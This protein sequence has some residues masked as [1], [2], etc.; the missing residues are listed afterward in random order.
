MSS[1][2]NDEKAFDKAEEKLKNNWDDYN[3]NKRKCDIVN[4]QLEKISKEDIKAQETQKIKFIGGS[5]VANV[6]FNSVGPDGSIY[7]SC[8][9][10]NRNVKVYF[11]DNKDVITNDMLKQIARNAIKRKYDTKLF[12]INIFDNK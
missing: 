9:G 5:R 8:K 1:D 2:N 6:F 11:K 7:T 10:E 12:A 3:Y 4:I